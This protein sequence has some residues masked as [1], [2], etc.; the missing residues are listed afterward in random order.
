M[1]CIPHLGARGGAGPE[2][3]T[4]SLLA[5]RKGRGVPFTAEAVGAF[6][7]ISCTGTLADGIVAPLRGI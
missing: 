7:F 6:W 5:G 3:G 1:F 4:Q 2:L